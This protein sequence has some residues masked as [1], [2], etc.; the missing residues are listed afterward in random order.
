MSPLSSRKVPS[1]RY[2]SLYFSAPALPFE[3]PRRSADDYL[4]DGQDLQIGSLLVKV[5]HTPGHSPGHVMFHLPEKQTLIGGD[6][7]IGGSIIATLD[8]DAKE[9]LKGASISPGVKAAAQEL[10]RRIAND[11]GIAGG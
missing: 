3:I 7:I 8:D 2:R 11:L 10:R 6:L 1:S 4:A 9:T 5:L